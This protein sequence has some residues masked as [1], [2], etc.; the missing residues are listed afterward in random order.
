MSTSK[1]LMQID[2]ELIGYSGFWHLR[3]FFL[4]KFKKGGYTLQSHLTASKQMVEAKAYSL[5]G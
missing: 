5:C 3:V 1:E 2:L 4:Q